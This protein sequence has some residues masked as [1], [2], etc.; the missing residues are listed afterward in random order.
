[1]LCYSLSFRIAKKE[2]EDSVSLLSEERKLTACDFLI[3][4]E[5]KTL[6]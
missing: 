4:Q 6:S 5:W 3:R 2:N 1:M